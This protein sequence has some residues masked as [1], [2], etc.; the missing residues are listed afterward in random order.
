MTI[1]PSHPPGHSL[2]TLVKPSLRVWRVELP[3]RINKCKPRVLVPWR[4]TYLKKELLQKK[5]ELRKGED[6]TIV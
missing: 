4:K 3:G 2:N 6:K 5:A 1:K